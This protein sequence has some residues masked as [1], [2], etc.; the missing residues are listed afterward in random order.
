MAFSPALNYFRNIASPLFT[1]GLY[2]N[3]WLPKT[4]IGNKLWLH[5]DFG[6]TIT[7]L[8]VSTWADQSGNGNHATQATDAKR[9]VY[10]AT[11][12][13]GGMPGLTYNSVASSQLMTPAI[14]LGTFT[15]VIVAKLSSTN[16]YPMVHKTDGDAYM[17]TTTG[18]SISVTKAAVTSGKSRAADWFADDAAKAVAWSY[19]GTHATHKLMING[20]NQTMTDDAG[21]GDPG[22]AAVSGPI[23]VGGQQTGSSCS[24]GIYAEFITYNRA[25]TAGELARLYVY[26]KA[27]WGVP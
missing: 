19:D 15:H 21:V 26:Q 18:S 8:G 25:L 17:W 24:N 22:T 16:R 10:S 3:A 5:S 20:T 12:W 11:S 7:G 14:S 23:Y 13:P 4:V 27:K 9:P 1:T 6:I 2:S